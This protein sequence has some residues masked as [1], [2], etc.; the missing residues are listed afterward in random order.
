AFIKARVRPS[1]R[2]A[3]VGVPGPGPQMGFTSDRTRAAAELLKVRGSLERIVSTPGGKFSI[4]EAYEAAA[5]NDAVISGILT[6]QS[7]DLT[8]DIGAAPAG[9]EGRAVDRAA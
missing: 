6:R 4:Q 1:D 7:S 2:I 3:I 9:T 5:G 8:G